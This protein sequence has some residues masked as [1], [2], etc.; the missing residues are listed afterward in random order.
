MIYEQEMQFPTS[1]PPKEQLDALL[2]HL[3]TYTEY[4]PLDPVE[5][6][7]A[8]YMAYLITPVPADYF[9]TDYRYGGIIMIIVFFLLWESREAACGAAYAAI[10]SYSSAEVWCIP[11][12]I[13]LMMYN[14]NRGKQS[15]Y[16]FYV[17]YPLHLTILWIIKEILIKDL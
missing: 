9:H 17:F 16:F 6:E 14:G 4:L 2:K 12:I 10:C 11:A 8:G 5:F 15:K 1:L 3:K 13:M 7:I